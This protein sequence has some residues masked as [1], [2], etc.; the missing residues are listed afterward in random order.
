MPEKKENQ[1]KLNNPITK[2][3]IISTSQRLN[4]RDALFF[5]ILNAVDGVP[6]K[7]ESTNFKK[8]TLNN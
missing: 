3:I 8:T 5:Q 6:D 1:A 4:T 2:K 7:P